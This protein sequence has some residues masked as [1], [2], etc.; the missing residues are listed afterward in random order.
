MGLLLWLACAQDSAGALEDQCADCHPTQ[1]DSLASSQLSKPAPS[2]LFHALQDQAADLHGEGAAAQCEA[3][4]APTVGHPGG[5]SCNSCHAAVGVLSPDLPQNGE[6]IWERFGPIQSSTSVSSP[7]HRVQPSELLTDAAL[8]GACHQVQ[9]PAAFLETPYQAWLES[10]A[11]QE[12]QHCADCH[13][14]EASHR[15]VGLGG[16]PQDAIDLLLQA[17][18]LRVEDGQVLLH[19]HNSGHPLPDGAAFSRRLSVQFLRG[20]TLL[21]EHPL[22]PEFRS[23]EGEERLSPLDAETHHLRS[24]PPRGTL[25]LAPPSEATEACLVFQQQH[26]DL[27]A[28]LG[29]DPL[30]AGPVWQVSCVA[31]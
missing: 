2:P 30:L 24:I 11:A 20:D 4:H 16:A 5:L 21:S 13:M 22:T 25:A 26:P 8:C 12:D 14:P 9:G 1:A 17:A 23:E 28:E 29:L 27:L 3:C 19:N 18:E 31:L 15:F 6:L 7:A 10:P